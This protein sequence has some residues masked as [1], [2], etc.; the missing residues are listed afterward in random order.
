[1]RLAWATLALLISGIAHAETAWSEYGAGVPARPMQELAQAACEI[2]ITLHG[3]IA[4]VEQRVRLANHSTTQSLAATADLVLPE[5]AL[6]AGLEV[7]HGATRADAAVA[8]ATGFA[9][10]RVMAPEVIGADPALLQA[11]PIRDGRPRFRLVVQPIEPTGEATITT[12]WTHTAEIRGGGLHLTLPARDDGPCRGSIHPQP[13]PGATVAR[14]RTGGVESSS[15]TFTLADKDLVIDVDLAF[16]RNQPLVWSHTEALGLGYTAQ[17]ITVLTPPVRAI[18]AKRVLFVVDGSRSMELIGRHRVIQIVRALAGMLARGTEIEAIVFDRSA[19]RVLGAWQAIDAKALAAIESAILTRTAGNGS[20][21]AAA[22][23]L[24]RQAL[25]DLRGETQLVLIT[26]GVLG[27]QQPVNS[28]AQIIAPLPVA[29][30]AVVLSRGRMYNTDVGTVF[31]AINRVGG[32]Y[33]QLDAEQ[34]DSA[35][36]FLDDWMRPSWLGLGLETPERDVEHVFWSRR[37][38]DRAF[39]MPEQLLG[40]SGFVVTSIAKRPRKPTLVGRGT[41]PLKVAAIAAGAAPIAEL[42]LA[43]ETPGDITET[44]LAKLRARHPVVDEQHALAVLSRTGKIAKSRRDITANGAPYTRMIA[45]EDPALP[46]VRQAAQ[47]KTTAAGGGSAIDRVSLEL[48]FKTQLQ[49]A[50]FTCYQ[51]ALARDHKLAGTAQFHI[52]IGRGE[53]TRAGVTGFGD[54]TFEACLLDA[55]YRVTPS[56]PNPDYNVDDRTIANYPLT[57]SVREQK[58]FVIAGDADSSSPLDIDAIKGGVPVKIK[59]GDTSTPLGDL[60]VPKTP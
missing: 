17:A 7:K 32:S 45:I 51:K 23:T 50:A 4:S 2:E 28:L 14:V 30:H 12:R 10:D 44:D 29:L 24:A 52:E 3:A 25:A 5:G 47:P 55:A 41:K 56:L 15:R 19:T 35:L 39:E 36:A 6:L 31:A 22:L 33:R 38:V 26:D 16:K 58:P 43:A 46:V 1:M 60:R 27:E 9:S 48:M 59:A 42:A 54:A 21:A 18:G 20:D 11:L 34:L 37:A 53:T 13:G 40:G 57:F 49:P 8:V